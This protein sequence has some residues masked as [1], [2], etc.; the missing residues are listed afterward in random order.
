MAIKETPEVIDY[1]GSIYNLMSYLQGRTLDIQV[2]RYYL[3]LSDAMDAGL[4]S[5]GQGLFPQ[6]I[7]TR[8]PADTSAV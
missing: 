6:L 8:P 5:L 2:A 7:T 3:N 4:Q 1:L